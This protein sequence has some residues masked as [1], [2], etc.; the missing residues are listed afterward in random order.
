MYPPIKRKPLPI[1][2]QKSVLWAIAGLGSSGFGIGPAS[3]SAA[4]FDLVN[5][6]TGRAH[7]MVLNSAGVGQ[8]FKAIPFS[9]SY[10]STP[11]C[12]FRT[13]EAVSFIEL[14]GIWMSVHEVNMVLYS[15]TRV[16]LHKT[17]AMNSQIIASCDLSG[18]GLSFPGAGSQFGNT[19]ILFSDGKPAE[20][21]S[22]TI[23]VPAPATQSAEPSTGTRFGGMNAYKIPTDGVFGFDKYAIKQVA[24]WILQQAADFIKVQKGPSQKLYV[25]GHTDNIGTR[26]YNLILSKRRADAVANWLVMNDVARPSEIVTSGM[27]EMKPI[28]ANKRAD[29]A[30][31]P[32][33]REKNRRVEILIM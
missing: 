15:V 2:A 28:H 18:G 24:H 17:S 20:P 5:R 3:V 25:T 29:G 10:G 11:Y 13:R 32:Y 1:D 4:L 33:G 14:N 7:R 23:E 19:E 9:G 26:A 27:G 30:D 12:S 31:H 16:A 6:S 8:G 22:V 21:G